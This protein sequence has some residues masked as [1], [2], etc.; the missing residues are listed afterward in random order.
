M[1]F[2][3]REAQEREKQFIKIVKSSPELLAALDMDESSMLEARVPVKPQ[4]EIL[5][6]SK[7]V[8]I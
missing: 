2:E 8:P 6:S 4:E 7:L 3:L 1:K 5:V